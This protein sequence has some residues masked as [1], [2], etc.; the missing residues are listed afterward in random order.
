MIMIMIMIVIMI[1]VIVKDYLF[2][3]PTRASAST[4]C[5]RI[6]WVAAAD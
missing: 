1:M 5:L 6:F 3:R 4:A 2:R